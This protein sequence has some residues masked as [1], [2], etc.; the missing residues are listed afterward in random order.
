MFVYLF[1]FLSCYVVG[2]SKQRYIKSVENFLLIFLALFLCSGFMCGSDWRG[3]ELIY[4]EID[5]NNYFYNYFAEPGFYIYLS[6]FKLVNF[7]FWDV[8]L[9]TKLLCYVSFIRLFRKILGNDILLCLMCFI[10]WSAFYLF[11][12]CPMRNLIAI[13]IFLLS[14]PYLIERNFIK[15]CLL[16]ILASTFHF[17]A[18][19]YLFVFFIGKNA[20]SNRLA[21]ALV[22]V[23][24]ILFIS[25]DLTVYI[26]SFICADIPYVG[27]KVEYYLIGNSEFAQGRVLSIG[28]LMQ[29]VYFTLLMWKKRYVTQAVY[30]NIV[31]NFSM[32]YIMLYRLSVTIEIFSRFQLY[33]APLFFVAIILVANSFAHTSRLLYITYILCTSLFVGY[34][35]ITH[36]ERFIPYSTYIPYILTKDYPSYE[37]RDS[38]NYNNSPYANQN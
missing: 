28:L 11:I 30:G 12:D 2:I 24:N 34:K 10:P 37:Y 15:Y 6:I 4:N 9:I 13:S 3:Y 35:K 29:I 19:I 36:D 23:V 21:V 18:L 20:I 1:S 26:V 32:I 33:V 17:S 27:A 22:L 8:S 14:I 31:F 16:I 7:D 38:F 5:F 25:K